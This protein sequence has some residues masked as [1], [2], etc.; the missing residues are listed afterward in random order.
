MKFTVTGIYSSAL[1]KMLVDRGHTPTKLSTTLVQRLGVEDLSDPADVQIRD[2]ARTQGVIVLGEGAK[3]I[4]DE[5]VDSLKDVAT[6]YLPKTYGAVYKA[7]IVEKTRRGY[8]I[9][10][11]DRLGL[12]RTRRP[13][14]E[15][16][17]V[18]VTGYSRSASKLILTDVVKIRKGAAE[19]VRIG[20]SN[21]D[22]YLPKRWRWRSTG[23]DIENTE[24]AEATSDIEESVE[25]PEVPDGRSVYQGIDYVELVFSSSVKAT[26]DDFRRKLVPTISGHHYLKS[27]GAAYSAFV[28]FG[29]RVQPLV[30]D[31]FDSLLSESIVRGVYPRHNE[32]VRILRMTP[33]GTD[34]QKWPVSVVHSDDKTI[35]VKHS[36]R[37]RENQEQPELDVL[38]GD[39]ATTEFRIGEWFSTTTFTRRNGG[40]VGAHVDVSTPPEP[41]KEFIRYIDLYVDVVKDAKEVKVLN[42]DRLDEAY[43]KGLVTSNMRDKAVEAAKAAE[44][45]LKQ[46]EQNVDSTVS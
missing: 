31:S 43:E 45:R 33:E 27:L 39:L 29:E 30:G 10:L 37:F 23:D 2:M 12:L 40:L 9:E 35:I 32:K 19:A 20:R 13:E 18:Q 17:A 5:I 25:S 21:S 6:M 46:G 44:E 7:R 36:V 4:S 42:L 3:Q 34:S 15:I 1:S 38:P 22:Q 14:Y 11:N 26:L 28:D 8:L 16:S 41:C 24:V